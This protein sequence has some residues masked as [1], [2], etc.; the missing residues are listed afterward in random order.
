MSMQALH[1]WE[2][3]SRAGDAAF[4]VGKQLALYAQQQT[5]LAWPSDRELVRSTRLS[6]STVQRALRELERA[7]EIIRQA[8]SP[9]R[10]RVYLIAPQSPHQEPLPGL[11]GVTHDTFVASGKGVICDVEGVTHAC[12]GSNP[13]NQRQ[14]PPS[15][16]KGGFAV[17][18]DLLDRLHPTGQTPRVTARVERVAPARRRRRRR[19]EDA[20]LLASG[21]CPLHGVTD[22]AASDRLALEE[23]WKHIA[24]RLRERI[25]E[26]TF[27][28]WLCDAHLHGLE[29][30][31][32]LAIDPPRLSWVAERWG[33]AIAAAAG[34]DVE[35]VACAGALT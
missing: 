30:G 7:G 22:R 6:K 16:P 23:H 25:G 24:S 13:Q 15:P 32:Q 21:P 12:A 31:L 18:P 27:E 1:S 14:D 19:G 11:E 9:G 35:I 28:L 29:S 5:D 2:A 10:R 33:R 3:H 26:T 4:I 8:A 17:A 20:P 34:V